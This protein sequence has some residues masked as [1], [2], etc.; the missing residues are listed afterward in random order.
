VLEE[1]DRSD[2]RDVK[3]TPARRGRAEL[4][5]LRASRFGLVLVG[6]GL[7]LPGTTGAQTEARSVQPLLAPALQSPDVVAFQ[8]HRYLAAKAPRLPEPSSP[9][10]WTAEAARLRRRVL[11]DVLL[12]GWPREW[13][14][15]PPRVEDL[16][17]IPSPPG[18]RMRRLRYE[19][20]PGFH[21]VGIL[22]EPETTRGR[23]PAILNVNGHHGAPGK[24]IEHK[25][26][27]CINQAK[28]GMFALNL[29]FLNQGE[30]VDPQNT[31]WFGAHL[32]LAGANGAGLFYL[33]IRKALD[34]LSAHPGVD[35][36][37]LGV[38]GLSG[39]GVQTIML[40]ALDERVSVAVPV[41]G[42][43]SF[44]SSL[45]RDPD[46]ALG[47]FEHHPTD[48]LLS[49]DL[50]ALTAM[51]APRPTLLVYNA[52]D[53]CCYRAPL[54][55][56][57]IFDR[58]Q[59]FFRLYGKEDAFAWHE[60]RDPGTHN[61]QLDNRLQSYAFFARYFGLPPVHEEIAGA[62]EIKS[63]EELRV[64][65]PKDNLTILRL[66]Q[67]LADRLRTH[68]GDRA[69]LARVVRYH[70]AVIERAWALANTKN[71][72]LETRSYR[73]DFVNGLSASGVWLKALAAQ[74]A[75]PVTIVLDDEGKRVAQAAVS[76]R[77]NR[78]EEVLALD[79]LFTGDAAPPSSFRGGKNLGSA[80]YIQMIATAGERALGL[81]A[82]QLIALARS[83]G[84]GKVRLEANGIRSQV[85]ALVAAALE[86]RLFSAVVV[87]KGMP[88]LR[89]VFD[90]PVQSQTAMDLF[91]LDLYKEFDL[92]RLAEL[93]GLPK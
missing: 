26:K 15:A 83:F 10:S 62:G 55:K 78:G 32:D 73:F 33:A 52:E 31:H 30:L 67:Q 81:E 17:S 53:D 70:D 37:R 84:R 59:P 80:A 41:A 12:H 16:G 27:R 76:E 63:A 13:V 42:Y 7:L 11:D 68:H 2:S 22:Y 46:F 57:D 90:A 50:P 44:V 65:L 75:A 58:V 69:T 79:L 85:T 71:N 92:D 87:S 56:P 36:A 35:P 28:L 34:Y 88:S 1:S 51:R 77:V 72:G 89:Y 20:V 19:I 45:E 29:E 6:I 43:S 8:L 21:S 54:V 93:A 86:P 38:T 66:A 9:E 48:L 82:A 24:A 40:G 3:Q 49:A 39:G 18:Y 47:H 74:P 60:N 5:A 64:G 14:D 91:C 4:L 25:Q 61:Y 23:V